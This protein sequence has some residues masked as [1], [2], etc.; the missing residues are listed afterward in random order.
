MSALKLEK[1]Y[2]GDCVA[3]YGQWFWR[4]LLGRL[5][6][7]GHRFW[8]GGGGRSFSLSGVGLGS[9]FRG[10]HVCENLKMLGA[11]SLVDRELY[12]TALKLR[13]GLGS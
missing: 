6:R 5:M 2:V 9:P 10:E 13:L 11:V 1:T 4:W 12:W 8:F 3:F 7:C